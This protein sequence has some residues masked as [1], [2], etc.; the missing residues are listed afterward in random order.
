M[1]FDAT[2]LESCSDASSK[3][4]GFVSGLTSERVGVVFQQRV[5]ELEDRD[6]GPHARSV[7]AFRERFAD[8]SA[9]PRYGWPEDD[10]N[11]YPEG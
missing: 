11:K 7:R 10:L 1:N 4:L 3:R 9:L 2:H 5:R 8:A 6:R